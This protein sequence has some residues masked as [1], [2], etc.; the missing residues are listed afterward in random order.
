MYSHEEDV[1]SAIEVF[2]QAIQYY[3]KEQVCYKNPVGVFQRIILAEMNKNTIYS[4]N[5]FL[6][7]GNGIKCLH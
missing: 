7:S 2:S 5:A 4:Q 6:N 3:Q 1:D